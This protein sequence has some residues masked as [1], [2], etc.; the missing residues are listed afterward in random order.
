MVIA[1]KEEAV[2]EAMHNAIDVSGT[3]MKAML[4]K[5]TWWARVPVILSC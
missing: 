3:D 1:G 4:V 2:H 5:S